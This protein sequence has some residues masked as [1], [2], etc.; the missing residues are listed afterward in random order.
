[1]STLN[2]CKPKLFFFNMRVLILGTEHSKTYSLA[3][4]LLSECKKE[5]LGVIPWISVEVLE[6]L[7]SLIK[8]LISGDEAREKF[9]EL[10]K[11]TDLVIF[12]DS[13]WNDKTQ[14][15]KVNEK[16]YHNIFRASVGVVSLGDKRFH[17]ANDVSKIKEF[18]KLCKV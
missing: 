5:N 4:K 6:L 3:F 15:D 13:P 16:W 10:T 17:K 9:K 1:M 7:D 8:K 2:P 18:I 11:D 14:L 12:V